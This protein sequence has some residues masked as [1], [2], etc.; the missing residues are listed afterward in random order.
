LWFFVAVF[1]ENFTSF[2]EILKNELKYFPN[3]G[4]E[5][6]KLENITC[7]Y[8]N[9]LFLPQKTSENPGDQLNSSQKRHHPG[10]GRKSVCFQ[11]A[12]V[13]EHKGIVPGSGRGEHVV[14]PSGLQCG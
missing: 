12:F 5:A 2:P 4:L 3:L 9:S 13:Q 11:E 14:R 6:G 1:Q 7:C 8:S 10:F